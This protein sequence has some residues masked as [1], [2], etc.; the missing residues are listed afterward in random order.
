MGNFVSFG[1]I[2]DISST[3]DFHFFSRPFFPFLTANYF[4][5]WV[6]LGELKHTVASRV[7]YKKLIILLHKDS[8]GLAKLPPTMLV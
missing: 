8:T 4:P 5:G 7:T 6:F 1:W 2:Y 3:G